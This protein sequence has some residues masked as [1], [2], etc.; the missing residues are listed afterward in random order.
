MERSY[1]ITM[2]LLIVHQIDAAYWQEWTMFN[3]PGGIQVYLLFNI[4]I[5][6]IILLGFKN[7]ILKK[8]S[9]IGF[10]YLCA[11][12]GLITFII[13][14]VFLI[15]EYHQFTLPLSLLII[16][17]CFFSALHLLWLT[18]KQNKQSI[19]RQIGSA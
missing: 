2:C 17:L 3:L 9:A 15:L 12:L 19:F 10:S 13:H 18:H 5:I 7:V 6:P 14:S 8:S 16:A 1:L 11:S 4:I